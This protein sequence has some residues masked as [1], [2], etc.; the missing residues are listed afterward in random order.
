MKGN[1]FSSAKFL[2][3]GTEY[4]KTLISENWPKLPPINAMI[5]P[6]NLCNQNCVR[7]CSSEYR[8]RIPASMSLTDME[9]VI[10][11]LAELGC[12]AVLFSGGGEPL[13]NSKVFPAAFYR[14]VHS[15]MKCAL[16]TNGVVIHEYL[17][18][19]ASACTY[20]KISI[21]AG[22][23]ETYSILHRQTSW[24]EV[25]GNI[26]ELRKIYAGDIGAAFLVHPKN[27]TE[28]ENFC[29]LARNQ[30]MSY[31]GIRPAQRYELSSR[32][33]ESVKA[34]IKRFK[35]KHKDFPVFL[36]MERLVKE[37]NFTKC[38]A[39][40][41][42]IAIGPELNVYPCC[43]LLGFE[44][45]CLGNLKE[46]TLKEIWLGE[47]RGKIVETINPEECPPCKYRTAN[48]IL[49]SMKEATHIEFF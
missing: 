44:K 27:Y 38:L 17:K 22:T 45:Y 47:K 21:D 19:I 35:Q 41:L 43:H 11:Q 33:I 5:T 4:I 49:N 39:T 25:W 18:A 23:E 46:Q 29:L 48:V 37:K 32:M 1:P 20:V 10:R 30:V 26:W 3:A 34:Q 31:A 24:D 8:K 6:T 40:P 15:G 42:T 9:S 13:C 7:C 28:L 16:T 36:S 12:K 14:V 2:F